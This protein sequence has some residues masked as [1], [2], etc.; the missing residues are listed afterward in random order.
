MEDFGFYNFQVNLENRDF[1]LSILVLLA[2]LSIQKLKSFL[3][4]YNR[5]IILVLLGG[6]KLSMKV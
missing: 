2:Q 3:N 4:H 1:E 6:L 5:F